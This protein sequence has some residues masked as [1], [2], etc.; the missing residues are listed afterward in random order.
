MLTSIVAT[1]VIKW[2]HKIVTRCEGTSA[3]YYVLTI[4]KNGTVHEVKTSKS[5][6]YLHGFTRGS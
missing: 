6:S 5:L 3:Q 4:Y 2:S 1:P